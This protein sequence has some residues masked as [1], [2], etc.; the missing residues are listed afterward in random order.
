MAFNSL[1]YQFIVGKLLKTTKLTMNSCANVVYY[2]KLGISCLLICESVW[3]RSQ[4]NC[5]V[6]SY[7]KSCECV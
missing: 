6:D 5:E 3:V 2:G 4:Y 1:W 7:F